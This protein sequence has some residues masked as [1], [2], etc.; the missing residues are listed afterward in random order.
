MTFKDQIDSVYTIYTPN[1]TVEDR[2]F[3]PAAGA[4]NLAGSNDFTIGLIEMNFD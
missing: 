4:R 3:L 1:S 2:P